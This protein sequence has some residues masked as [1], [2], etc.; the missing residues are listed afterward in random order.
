MQS[1]LQPRDTP[2]PPAFQ[3]LTDRSYIGVERSKK[4]NTDGPKCGLYLQS[5]L[6]FCFPSN[7]VDVQELW[8]PEKLSFT[9]LG[10]LLAGFGKRYLSNSPLEDIQ[11]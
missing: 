1:S 6:C 9:H 3:C 8:K 2:D 10:G 7:S 5:K 4:E 11:L